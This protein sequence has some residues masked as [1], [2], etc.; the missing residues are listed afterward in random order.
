[1]SIKEK[2]EIELISNMYVLKH[3]MNENTIYI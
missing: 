2:K 1:M 3:N